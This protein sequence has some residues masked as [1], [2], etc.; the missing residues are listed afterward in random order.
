ML[1][2]GGPKMAGIAS[3]LPIA[4]Y[5]IIEWTIHTDDGTPVTLRVHGAYVPA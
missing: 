3:G 1:S 5:G 2:T 4:G